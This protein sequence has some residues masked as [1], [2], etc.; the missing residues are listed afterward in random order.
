VAAVAPVLY[1]YTVTDDVVALIARATRFWDPPG[2]DV[3]LAVT[4][5]GTVNRP[6]GNVAVTDTPLP[7][8]TPVPEIVT[9]PVATASGCR[10]APGGPTKVR[11]S[12]IFAAGTVVAD[13]A[14]RSRARGICVDE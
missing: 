7:A 6:T 11:M 2:A 9:E 3:M 1:R 13:A 12:S 4:I 8:A 14:W 10:L 5:G